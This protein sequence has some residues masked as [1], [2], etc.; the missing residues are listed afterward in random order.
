MP[1]HLGLIVV[2]LLVENSNDLLGFHGVAKPPCP[3]L[4]PLWKSRAKLASD[5]ENTV[6]N[7]DMAD[8]G[9]TGSLESKPRHDD[10]FV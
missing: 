3:T 2:K 1:F 7:L 5:R 4:T 10:M 8:S 6:T 9:I